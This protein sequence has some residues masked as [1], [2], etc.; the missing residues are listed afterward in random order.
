MSKVFI[1]ESTLTA[2]GNA[3]RRKEGTSALI[4]PGS[5]A[6]KISNLPT[7]GGVADV[8]PDDLAYKLITRKGAITQLPDNI[9]EIGPYVFY[10]ADNKLA[11]T[12]LPNGITTI[13]QYAFANSDIT[14]TELPD[15]VTNIGQYAFDKCDKVTLSRLPNNLQRIG[16]G[17]FDVNFI[18][19]V[20][21][22]AS[23]GTIENTVF[24]Y[25]N[26]PTVTEVIFLGKPTNIYS[27]IFQRQTSITSIKVPWS[28]GEVAG[29]PWGATNATITYNYVHEEA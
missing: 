19:P 10:N 15:S 11:L 18:S 28:E 4:P 6:T 29:A 26:N 22:P 25:Y 24:G 21:F 12:S 16:A 20:I 3:I 17:A 13:G 9:T 27:N 8:T 7:G 23:L 14:I 2:I 1:E 5:M